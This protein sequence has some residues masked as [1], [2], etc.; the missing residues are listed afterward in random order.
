ML[1]F[2]FLFLFVVAVISFFFFFIWFTH[3]CA[4]A[5]GMI[6]ASWACSFRVA[7]H[8]LLLQLISHRHVFLSFPTATAR[9]VPCVAASQLP[10]RS[11]RPLPSPP[12]PLLFN[13]SCEWRIHLISLIAVTMYPHG[14]L[15][16]IT[17]QCSGHRRRRRRRRCRSKVNV[18]YKQ[19]RHVN[20][21]MPDC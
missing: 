21:C 13:P 8:A 4:I 17:G 1:C 11:K 12:P 5:K 2:L 20:S 16:S 15:T 3:F 7:A 19:F 9:G 18:T 6:S 10:D 14:H